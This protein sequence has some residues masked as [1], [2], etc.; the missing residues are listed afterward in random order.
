[1][2]KRTQAA[3]RHR[4]SLKKRVRNYALRSR[5][6]SFIKSARLAINGDAENKDEKV[7]VACR[8]LDRMATKGIIH[9]NNASR[10]KSRLMTALHATSPDY[11]TPKTEPGFMESLSEEENTV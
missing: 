1:M 7:M 6:R 10:R 4:Q 3:K 11:K 2:A 9:K 8:E 5:L